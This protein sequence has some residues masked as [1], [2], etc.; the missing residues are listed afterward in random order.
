MSHVTYTLSHVTHTIS[1]VESA[2]WCSG[3]HF[4]KWVMSHSLESCHT[5]LSHVILSWVMSNI[6]WV[7]S[8]MQWVM[9]RVHWVMS[10]SLESCQIYN[11]S[12]PVVYNTHSLSLSLSS[13]WWCNGSQYIMSRIQWVMS[14]IQCIK[15][16]VNLH[17]GYVDFTDNQHASCHMYAWVMSHI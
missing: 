16:H 3:S 10:H 11:V 5:L 4:I 2:W 12:D 7:M 14:N 9:S 6:Q 8:N 13:A 1:Q 15:F 17:P